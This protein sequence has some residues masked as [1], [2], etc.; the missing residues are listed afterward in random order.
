[1]CRGASLTDYC[2][3]Y[4]SFCGKIDTTDK[5]KQNK[6]NGGITNISLWNSLF[7]NKSSSR[8]SVESDPA[9]ASIHDAAVSGNLTAAQAFLKRDPSLVSSKDSQ[10]RMPLHFAAAAGQKTMVEF[11][12]AH[13]ADINAKNGEGLTPLALAKDSGR[14][15]V[16]DLIRQRGGRD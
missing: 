5:T 4:G 6:I 1:M 11:L 7:G 9:Y 16:V 3:R 12:L 8:Q 14:Q 13:K 2:V 10:G 15:N